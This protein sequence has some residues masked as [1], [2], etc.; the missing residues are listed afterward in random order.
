ML[1][2]V[3]ARPKLSTLDKMTSF[4]VILIFIFLVV[5]CTTLGLIDSIWELIHGDLVEKYIS[6]IDHTFFYCF[7]VTSL[8]YMLIFGN[9]VPISMVLTLEVSKFAQGYLMSIDKGLISSNGIECKVQSSNLNEELGQI[10]YIFSDKTGTLTQNEMRFKYFVVGNRVFGEKYGYTGDM[11]KVSNVDFSDPTLW[12]LISTQKSQ[13]SPQALK[14]MKG[15]SLLAN[16]HTIVVEKDGDYNASSPDELA[17]VNFAK[18]VGCEFQGIDD[19]NNMLVNEFG[20]LKRY[21]LLDVFEFDSDRKRM[22]IVVQDQNGSIIM[23]CKGA[24][25]IMITRYAENGKEELKE[26]LEHVDRFSSIGLR[27]LLLGYRDLTPQQYQT[28]KREYDV[29]RC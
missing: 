25:N 7:V 26:L 16:C 22:S 12:E 24:D 29:I 3:N 23:Y 18:L 4:F 11:P 21:K 5:I 10:D 27:T 6:G 15:I 28:F 19:D 13:S 17:F 20:T 8:N 2:S 14:V 9:F 1:N